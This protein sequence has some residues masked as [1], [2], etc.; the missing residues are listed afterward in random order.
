MAKKRVFIVEDEEDI[1]ELLR[2]H[3]EREGYSVTTS[4]NGEDALAAVPAAMPHL[5]LLDLMLPGLDGLEVCRRLKRDNLTADIPVI[6][7]TAKGEEGDVVTGLE[8][9]AEDY[10]CKPFSMK[11]LVARVRRVLRRDV[12]SV[13][14]D[15]MP[16]Q[17]HDIVIDPRRRQVFIEGEAI[18][19]TG[20][21]FALL[22]FLAE[23][24]GWVM[25]RDQIIDAVRGKDYA[26]TDRAVD[27]QVVGLRKKLGSR[28]EYIQTV[29]GVGYRFKE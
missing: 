11:I 27:V 13:S 7:V 4:V 2:Y 10:I 19:L 22:H 16:I 8:L 17:I 29:R 14:N 18:D 12:A 3:L 21:E 28:A 15:G 20:T 26:V 25:T 24:A 1:L 9:G 5:I 23:R 6:M